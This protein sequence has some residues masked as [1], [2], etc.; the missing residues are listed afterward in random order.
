M[1]TSFVTSLYQ[2]E[3][4]SVT[5]VPVPES[6]IDEL[7][8]GKKPAVTITVRG[9]SMAE[10][11]VYRSTVASM[12]GQF[13][14]SFSSASRDATGLKAGDEI[15][16]TLELDDQ[17][18][19]IETPHDLMSSLTE[20]GLLDTFLGLSYSKQRGY[21]EPIEAAKTVETRQRRVEK[22]VTD[23]SGS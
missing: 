13:L 8:A 19:T 3:G 20:A 5:G 6:A 14:I 22:V 11:F 18:R 7:G 4:R 2:P 12:G 17:P 10:S 9:A 21:V 23:L 16:V 1:K 15:D